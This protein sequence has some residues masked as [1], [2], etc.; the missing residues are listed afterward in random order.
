MRFESFVDFVPNLVP[1]REGIRERDDV[2]RP[3]S[4]HVRSCHRRGP[5]G[6]DPSGE[7]GEP[8]YREIWITDSHDSHVMD[9][10]THGS[11]SGPKT[12]WN[13][14]WKGQ[15]EGKGVNLL[16]LFQ[17]VR[18]MEVPGFLLD[19][20]LVSGCTPYDRHCRRGV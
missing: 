9:H 12:F 16:P 17:V 14:I 18:K 3:S 4:S 8:T 19:S 13:L 11:R 2:C 1:T 5:G 10:M 15:S 7:T 6:R 20:P